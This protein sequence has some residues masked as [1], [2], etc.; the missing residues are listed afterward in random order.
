M[1]TTFDVTALL[2][3]ALG[4]AALG[5][6][7]MPLHT[8]DEDGICDC[9]QRA[10][11]GR[12]T[13]KHPRTLKGLDDSSIDEAKIRRWWKMWPHANIAID[14]VRSG[15]VDVAPDSVDWHAE[16]IARGLP[17]TLTFASGAGEGHVHYLYARSAVCPAYRLTQTG[18]Y[19]ILSAGYAVVPPSLH[20]SGRRY[21]WLTPDGENPTVLPSTAEPAWTLATLQERVQRRQERPQRPLDDPDGPPVVLRGDALERWYGRLYDHRPD[22]ELDRSYSLWSLAVVLL[23]AGLQPRLAEDALAERDSSLGWTKFTERRDSHERYRVIVERAVASQGPRRVRLNG[24]NG[25]VAEPQQERRREK[26]PASPLGWETIDE[27]N[28]SEDE[29]VNWSAIGIVGDGLITEIDG[30][31]KRSGK[32]TLLLALA[33]AILHGEPFFGQPTAYAPVVYLTEQSGPSFKR[34]LR[35]SGLVDGDAF[36][37]LRWGRTTDWTWEKLIPEVLAK[38]DQLG[39]RVLI[40]DTLPQ[41]SGVRGDDENRSGAALEVME[42]LQAATSRKLGI[43][44]SRH[45]RKAGGAA[46]DSARG[47]SAFAGA[48]DIVLHLDRPEPKPGNERQRVLE[49]LSRFEETPVQMLIELSGDE[50][51]S[52]VVVG[53][54]EEIKARDLRADILAALPVDEDEAIDHKELR[55]LVHGDWTL[56]HRT[57]SQLCSEHLAVRL[58]RGVR[59]D[60]YRYYQRTWTGGDDD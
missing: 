5:W 43:V 13:G 32:T 20:Q 34:S 6:Y 56:I 14:L 53:D 17:P 46:G 3:A 36:T 12:N 49:S 19:D 10:A 42:P 48:V 27:F 29:D 25:T 57:L 9:P 58:G 55:E 28:A 21:T 51:Q 41:F 1:T 26:K 59:H 16:F 35:R 30:K 38:V 60:A 52:Y 54:V 33:R 23:A 24:S 47:S 44:I 45:D 15:L 22:G 2:Q 4:Y 37:L 8:P 31:A 11:C 50:P 18:E 40:I 39:A 7:V